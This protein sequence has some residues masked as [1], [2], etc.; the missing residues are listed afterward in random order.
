VTASHPA[1]VALY[2]EVFDKRRA[3]SVAGPD[4]VAL[5]EVVIAELRAARW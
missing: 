4:V 1:D 3:A 2:Q 5:I